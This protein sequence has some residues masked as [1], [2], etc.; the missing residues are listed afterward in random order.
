MKYFNLKPQWSWLFSSY[1]NLAYPIAG[2]LALLKTDNPLN[3]F[4][5]L[6]LLIIGIGSYS[7]HS[8]RNSTS[9]RL[10]WFAMFIGFGLFI[11]SFHILSS[12]FFSIV[13]VLFVAGVMLIYP[14]SERFSTMGILYVWLSILAY[15]NIP[16]EQFWLGQA[17]MAV[18]FAFRQYGETKAMIV[19]DKLHSIW[20][21]L[22]AIGLA[23]LGTQP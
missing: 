18:G 13:I 21:V 9:R 11:L 8:T 10:D 16:S 17:F 5:F 7:Y 23:L 6:G 3:Y 4:L 1:S 22:V 2:F 20:H 14:Y 12:I 19:D 15:M